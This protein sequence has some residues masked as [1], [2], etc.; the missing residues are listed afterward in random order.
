[1][2]RGG[3][4][5]L[6][7]KAAVV[8]LPLSAA[9]PCAPTLPSSCA[10]T[11]PSAVW[12]ERRRPCCATWWIANAVVRGATVIMQIE[13]PSAQTSA[14]KASTRNRRILIAQGVGACSFFLCGGVQ[15]ARAQL[16]VPTDGSELAP[17]AKDG[18]P[19]PIVLV[20]LIQAQQQLE[21]IAEFI[22]A[23]DLD[24]WREAN[25]ALARKPFFPTKELKRLFNA[26]TDNIYFSDSSRR[27]MYLDGRCVCIK[28]ARARSL[29]GKQDPVSQG[30][31]IL[32][33]SLS[34]PM[35]FAVPYVCC[36]LPV[37][38]MCYF[39]VVVLVLVLLLSMSKSRY[40]IYFV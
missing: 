28:F 7:M 18:K 33:L 29:S 30:N 26:Y 25:L 2:Q 3:I 13:R 10:P 1:M 15:R 37:Y 12:G 22:E 19:S 40:L 5:A 36:A 17:I 34:V 27:N 16:Y 14:Q 31:S 11:L 4:L 23:G 32:F 20:P 24:S 8:F 21:R 9:F 38:G 35:P 6:L 39:V